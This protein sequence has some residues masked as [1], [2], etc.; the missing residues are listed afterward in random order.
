[1][2]LP[3]HVLRTIAA[4]DQL[5][6]LLLND[7]HVPACLSSLTALECLVINELFSDKH[8]AEDQ[9]AVELGLAHLQRLTY[10]DMS[11][12]RFDPPAS[13]TA[14]TSLRS[15]CWV[16]NNPAVS[17]AP[18]PA[19][20]WLAGLERLG[21]TWHGALVS[22]PSLAAATQLRA[23]GL[24]GAPCSQLQMSKVIDHILH[25]SSVR[26]VY[27]NGGCCTRDCVPVYLS[28]ALLDAPRQRSDI[29]LSTVSDFRDYLFACS[30]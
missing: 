22:L 13:L 28:G 30:R 5:T 16:P 18:L 27:V 14:L 25:S 10:L 8:D 7:A 9:Q 23:L 20:A 26:Q 6:R 17:A 21:I 3:E 24:A 29:H 11:S 12:Y 15:F 19:G 4:F 2:R 1:M